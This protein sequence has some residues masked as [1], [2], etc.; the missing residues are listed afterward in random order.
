MKLEKILETL[1]A[2]VNT[3]P[4]AEAE[5]IRTIAATLAGTRKS[6]RP[7]TKYKGWT[8]RTLPEA[9]TDPDTPDT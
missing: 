3:L 8:M 1:T 2:Y 9:P 5:A 4:E 7:A 6:A